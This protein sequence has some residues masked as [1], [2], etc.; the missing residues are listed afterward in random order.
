MAKAISDRIDGL[1][2][3][4]IEDC[5]DTFFEVL[6][7]SLAEGDAYNQKNFGTFKAVDR[8]ARVGRNPQTGERVEIASSKALKIVA[9]SALKNRL[10]G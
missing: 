9:S 7:D 8:A 10:N 6:V 3:T 5:I 4:Q 1:T 2:L